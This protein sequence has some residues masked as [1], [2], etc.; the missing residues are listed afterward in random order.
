MLT[1]RYTAQNP[2]EAT[3]R[4]HCIMISNPAPPLSKPDSL[5]MSEG[6]ITMFPCSLYF[7]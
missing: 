1:M 5:H 3:V 6:W 7:N 2:D 4:L